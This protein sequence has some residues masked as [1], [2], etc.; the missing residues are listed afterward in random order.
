MLNDSATSPSWTEMPVRLAAEPAVCV[1]LVVLA[2]DGAMEGDLHAFLWEEHLRICTTRVYAPRRNTLATLTQLQDRLA[3]AMTA[4]VP[5]D[6]LDVA[7]FGC[8]S[9]AMAL[10][11]ATVRA[12]LTQGRP[13]LKVT[14][15]VSAGRLLS[16]V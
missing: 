8:T 13:V 9:G 10:G 6:R 14:D 4:L 5:E 2:N 1:G 3:A 7:V 12:A 11:P 15:P 16:L